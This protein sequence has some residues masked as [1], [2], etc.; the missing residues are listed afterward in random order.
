MSLT[1]TENIKEGECNRKGGSSVPR[2]KA[3]ET[4]AI[5]KD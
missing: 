5:V 4:K 2:A 3:G 1:K